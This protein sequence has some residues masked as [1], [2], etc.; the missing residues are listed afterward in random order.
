MMTAQLPQRQTVQPS[1]PSRLNT[2]YLGAAG[3]L[4][5]PFSHISETQSLGFFGQA[6]VFVFLTERITLG[7]DFAY[8][9]F[10]GKKNYVDIAMQEVLINGAYFFNSKWNP[11]VSL[12]LGYYGEPGTS[13]FGM[14]P[15]VGIMPRIAEKIYFKARGS[16]AF[17]NMDGHFFK[18]E[19]GVVFMV[20]RHKPIPKY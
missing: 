1:E 19:A 14:V 8:Y 20:F 17:F 7:A 18:V 13:H 9:Y 10:L 5:I 2:V 15:G 11:H 4:S 6:E 12:G 3:G 16:A